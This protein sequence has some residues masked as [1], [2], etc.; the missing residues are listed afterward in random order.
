MNCVGLVFHHE[1]ILIFIKS[2]IGV[3]IESHNQQVARSQLHAP[4]DLISFHIVSAHDL[5]LQSSSF[6]AQSMW[7]RFLSHQASFSAPG[8]IVWRIVRPLINKILLSFGP[9]GTSTVR[10]RSFHAHL[11]TKFFHIRRTF[12]RRDKLELMKTTTTDYYLYD[13]DNL[14]TCRRKHHCSIDLIYLQMWLKTRNDYYYFHCF[15]L[16]AS[17]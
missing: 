5:Q 15:S 7:I 17:L 11:L 8:A 9:P 4:R 6:I 13:I 14:F 12:W 1:E 10:R 16:S 2:D 3:T